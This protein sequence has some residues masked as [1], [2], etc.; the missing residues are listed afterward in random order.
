EVIIAGVGHGSGEEMP[1]QFALNEE[2]LR[3]VDARLNNRLY[4]VD[5]NLSSRAGP[6]IVDGLEQFARCIHP[7]I[8]GPPDNN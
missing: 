2:R 8:F 7:E 5:S 3:D 4:G 1:L 6:R